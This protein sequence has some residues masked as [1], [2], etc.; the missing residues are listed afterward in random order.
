[1]VPQVSWRFLALSFPH[2][3]QSNEFMA[4]SSN[5]TDSLGDNQALRDATQ[6]LIT[7]SEQL[8]A[9]AHSLVA[10]SAKLCERSRKLCL[11]D[12]DNSSSVTR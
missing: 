8:R 9:E 2:P 11:F 7:R 5:K 6:G 12:S 3:Q 4:G 10:V 1:M